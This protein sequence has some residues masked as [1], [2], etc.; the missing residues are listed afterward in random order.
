MILQQKCAETMLLVSE[1]GDQLQVQ[2]QK[3]A[4]ALKNY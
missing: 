3:L 1:G 2:R 4:S